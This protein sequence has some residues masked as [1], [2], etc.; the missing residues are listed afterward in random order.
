VRRGAV[1]ALTEELK[2]E[3]Q[4]VFDEAQAVAGC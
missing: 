2:T 4:M 1:A 3:L